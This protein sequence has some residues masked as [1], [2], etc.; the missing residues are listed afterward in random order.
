MKKP[1]QSSRPNLLFAKGTRLN[2]D[3]V[4]IKVIKKTISLHNLKRPQKCQG[5]LH[6]RAIACWWVYFM[7]V[8]ACANSKRGAVAE[9]PDGK[10]ALKKARPRKKM[11]YSRIAKSTV[12]KSKRIKSWVGSNRFF[13][14]SWGQ[15]LWFFKKIE[16]K[17]LTTSSKELKASLLSGSYIQTA[18]SEHF[19]SN[20]HS[21][22]YIGYLSQLKHLDVNAIVSGKHARRTSFGKPKPSNLWEWTNVTNYNHYVIFNFFLGLFFL[23]ASPYHVIPCNF[24]LLFYSSI[25]SVYSCFF[26]NKPDKD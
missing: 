7:P 9:K 15:T 24:C 4:S 23:A 19:L 5:R 11:W 8:T 16:V 14:P 26:P 20:S 1:S 12:W 21:V 13:S 22:T 3:T 17:K 18:V 6:T 25:Y 2:P 10:R